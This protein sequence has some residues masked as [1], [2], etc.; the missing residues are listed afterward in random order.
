MF[1]NFEKIKSQIPINNAKIATDDI[2]AMVEGKYAARNAEVAAVYLNTALNA[3]KEKS[4]QKEHK[5]KL[6]VAKQNAGKP[7]T[8]NNNLIMD[9]NDLIKMLEG[10]ETEN[11]DDLKVI[12]NET[13]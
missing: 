4:G 7:G 6:S 13:D 11:N 8:V 5:D 10:A 9:R 1:T 2:T 12:P 3:A